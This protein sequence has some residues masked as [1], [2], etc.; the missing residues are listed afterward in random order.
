VIVAVQWAV[1]TYADPRS[2]V[3]WVALAGAGATSCYGT[4]FRGYHLSWAVHTVT[5]NK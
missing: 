4:T 1:V 2:A 3:F 5:L